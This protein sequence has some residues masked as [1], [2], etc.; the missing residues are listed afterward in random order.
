MCTLQCA[1]VSFSVNRNTSYSTDL[2]NVM[3]G[4]GTD[5]CMS[6]QSDL[7][8]YKQPIK[9]LVKANVMLED[10]IPSDTAQN[11]HVYSSL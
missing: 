6:H 1:Y 7:I 4:L 11:G 9:F 10:F 3:S 8:C 5:V 2:G